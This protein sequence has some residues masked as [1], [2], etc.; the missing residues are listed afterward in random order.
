MKFIAVFCDAAVLPE[1]VQKAADTALEG[2]GG[3]AVTYRSIRHF[4]PAQK[5]DFAGAV[6]DGNAPKATAVAETLKIWGVNAVVVEPEGK[7]EG[8]ESSKDGPLEKPLSSMSNKE[9]EA[10]AQRF[11]ITFPSAVNTK[12][13]R[14]AFIETH[15]AEQAAR[16]SN[17]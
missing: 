6:V 10:E 15:C 8:A 2:I 11:G 13:E 5:E 4:N 1:T 12:L 7:V 9:L 3:S 14:V 17:S 16:H